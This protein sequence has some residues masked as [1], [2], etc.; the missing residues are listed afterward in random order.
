LQYGDVLFNTRNTLELV[1]KVAIWKN[2]LNEA[3]FNS[4][5]MRIK[6]RPDI[7]NFFMNYLFNYRTLLV[8]LK[9]IATGTTSVGAIYTR[10]LLGLQV[11]IPQQPEQ[12]AIAKTLLNIDSL[13]TSFDRLIEKKKNIKQGAMQELLTGKKRLPGG[14]IIDEGKNKSDLGII[15]RD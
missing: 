6:F 15:P 5:L 1:G 10:D 9:S 3:Y 11:T 2:E 8:Q 4:N 12:F 7:D 13:I 14:W